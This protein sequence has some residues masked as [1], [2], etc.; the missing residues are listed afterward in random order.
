MDCA[1][2]GLVAQALKAPKE[3][4]YSPLV[5]AG[6]SMSER[7][8]EHSGFVLLLRPQRPVFASGCDPLVH[9]TSSLGHHQA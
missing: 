7:L 8:M 6:S 4:V 2:G 3:R 5:F 1:A 9:V